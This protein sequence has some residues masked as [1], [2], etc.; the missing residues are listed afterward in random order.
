MF[1][2]SR[3]VTALLLVGGGSAWA[4]V[5]VPTENDPNAQ[6]AQPPVEAPRLPSGRVAARR[7]TA[8]PAVSGTASPYL[9]LRAVSV[10]DGEA[11]VQ[12]A[13]GA[14]TLR[15]GD[16]LGTDVVRAVDTG[17]IVL[18]RKAAPGAKGGDARVVVRFDG[19]GKPAVRIYYTED[20]TRVE[21][22]PKK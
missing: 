20:P 22:R 4:Q 10:T 2:L 12:T 5:P 21:P 19:Q 9:S 7:D 14:L 16:R 18:D 8:A 3:I 13:D 15:P 11:R 6:W 1:R 17:V